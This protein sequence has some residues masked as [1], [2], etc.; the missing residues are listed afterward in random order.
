MNNQDTSEVDQRLESRIGKYIQPHSLLESFLSF[1]VDLLCLG[2]V[3]IEVISFVTI[4]P[5][6]EFA[7]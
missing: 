5:S 1:L 6:V 7:R 4:I 3:T 2:P